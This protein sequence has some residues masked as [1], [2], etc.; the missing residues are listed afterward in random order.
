[1]MNL[2]LGSVQDQTSPADLVHLAFKFLY[3]ITKVTVTE[4]FIVDRTLN[5]VGPEVTFQ[6][7]V[8]FEG[9]FTHIRCGFYSFSFYPVLGIRY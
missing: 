7:V 8:S 3:I 1:M 6:T 4:Q 5:I 9:W 2:L